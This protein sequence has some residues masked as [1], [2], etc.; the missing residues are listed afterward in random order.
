M[1]FEVTIL[2]SSS[3]TP[4]HQG[5]PTAQV[6]NIRERFFLI[7]CGEGTQGQFLKYKF[8]LNKLSHIFI[9]HLHGD[10]YLGLVGL[11]STLHLQGRTTE[12]HIYGQP[13]LMDVIELQLRLSQTRLRYQLIF[14][15]V[16]H[17]APSIIYE[18]DDMLIKSIILNH[19]IPCTGYH[20]SEKP[21]PRKLIIAKLQQHNIPFSF[22]G[23]LKDGFDYEDDEGKIIPNAELTIS[24]TAPRSYAFC[25]D[26]CYD[27][28]IIDE[29]KGVNLLYHEATFMNDLAERAK[30]TFHSTSLQAA[31]IAKKA[32]VDKLIVGHFSARYR[33]L[34]P[35]L[36][37]ARTVFK[38]TELAIE[39]HKFSVE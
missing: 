25:S 37:E 30:T 13:E 21:K 1:N 33:D 32:G 8:K 34:K 39:G 16:Q 4:I 12:I 2:G 29:I 11:L 19:R 27:E 38:N 35:L 26:T 6:L 36:D 9:S 18:D 22:Y 15:P 5:H 20:F 31:T 3:A 17:Y 7:D 28:S 10:H 23:R 14:H 24:S